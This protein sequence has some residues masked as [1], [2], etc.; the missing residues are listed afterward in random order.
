MR[1]TDIA[2]P[3]FDATAFDLTQD[4]FMAHIRGR[5]ADGSWIEGVEV[6]RQVYAAIGLRWLVPL[7]RLPGISQLLD[8]LYAFFARNRLR[9]TGRCSRSTCG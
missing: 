3:S 5:S 2:D 4:D 9:W 1:F 8:R 7:T 6:F